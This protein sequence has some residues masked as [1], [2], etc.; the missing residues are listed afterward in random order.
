MKLDVLRNEL[1]LLGRV[2]VAWSGGV[3]SSL[4]ARVAHDT[5]GPDHV[6]AATAVSPSLPS[7]ELD[8]CR[9]LADEWGLRWK[10]V[11]T[12][13]MDRPEYRANAADR[14]AHCKE[15]LLD[16]LGPLATEIDAAVVLGVIV[17]DLS[18]DRPGQAVASSRGATFPLADARL[19]KADVRRLSKEMGLRT[20]DKPAAACLASRIPHGTEVT[21]A[22]LGRVERAEAA[23][24]RLGF[25]ALG[26]LRV[27]HQGAAAR[28]EFAPDELERATGNPDVVVDAIRTATGY[29][30]VVIDPRG[31]RVKGGV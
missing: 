23:L 20:W 17:D 14:C 4:L 6:L 25:G 29:R 10:V 22:L 11:E 28:V 1:R 26:P 12:D 7:A 19:T 8:E 21:V 3:D 24:R 15:A 18:D 31:Y 9:E 30:E 2:V 13:E 5:L 16:V 27:R